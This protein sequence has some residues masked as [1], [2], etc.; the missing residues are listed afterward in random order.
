MRYQ[1]YL[2]NKPKDTTRLEQFRIQAQRLRQSYARVE[3]LESDEVEVSSELGH[4][5][6]GKNAS[7]YYRGLTLPEIATYLSHRRVWKRIVEEDL[8]FGIILEDDVLLANSFTY[9]ARAITELEN[10][11]DVIK[12]AEPYARLRST[13]VERVGAA[14]LV[15]YPVI[16]LG[17]CAY[18]ISREAAARMLS[19][20]ESF[21][22]PLDVDM[23]WCW[24]PGLKVRGLR[25][26]PVQMSHRLGRS[27][28]PVA[29]MRKHQVRRLVALKEAI[30]YRWQR[31]LQSS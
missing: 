19:W 20:S 10:E 13:R 24:Q 16:P 18:V 26:Y 17:T 1:I 15:R 29:L 3:A 14:T 21:Y 28:K 12:L 31:R 9:V 23:Q 11:W 2:L 5:D 4:F 30:K 8:D 27:E 25:P 22:R 6:E 7:N